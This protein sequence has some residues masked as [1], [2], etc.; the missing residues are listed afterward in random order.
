MSG[1][2]AVTRS[3]IAGE[4][5]DEQTLAETMASVLSGKI[6]AVSTAGFLTA[7]AAKGETPREL[8]AVAPHPAFAVTGVS[9]AALNIWS[10]PPAPAAMADTRSIFRLPR[11]SWPRPLAPR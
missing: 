5:L 10:I 7:L 4:D 1:L 3:L 6:S 8:V 11:L 9:I 2:A